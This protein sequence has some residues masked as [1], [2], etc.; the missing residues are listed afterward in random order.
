MGDSRRPDWNGRILRT[1]NDREH[2]GLRALVVSSPANITYLC[3]FAG[4][5]GLL[6]LAPGDARLIVDGR[7]EAG[8]RRRLQTSGVDHLVVESVNKR[9]DCALADVLSRIGAKEVGFEA[10][11][12]TVATLEAWRRAAGPVQWRA[13][14]RLIERRRAIKDDGELQILREA[15]RRLAD[16]ARHTR[17]YVAEGRTEREV[18]RAIDQAIERAGFDAPAFPTIVAA[19]PNS[20]QPHARPTDRRLAR[21]DLVMLD[22]G[23]R[24]DGYCGDLTRMAAVGQVGADARSLFDAVREAQAAAI[25]AVRPGR[26]ASAVDTAAR[27]ALAQ[28]GLSEA[29]LHATGHGLG[30][31]LHE[32]PRI[33]RPD[34]THADGLETGMVCTIEPG[35]YVEGLGGVRLEDDVLVTPDG[36]EILTDVPRDLVIV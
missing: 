26:P 6:V 16:I 22:F 32:A 24:L 1:Q 31:E 29:M 33:A 14:E 3:G 30:L 28:R 13:T 19:G 9:Y 2:A 17:D 10:E 20:A 5:A 36:C 35:A 7:Y 11:H 27:D 18:A 34:P 21:G 12:V 8:A 23:G 25:A 4:T 15:C